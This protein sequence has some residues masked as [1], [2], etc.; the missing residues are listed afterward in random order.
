MSAGREKASVG[1]PSRTALRAAG[2]IIIQRGHRWAR[3][4]GRSPR[5]W[6]AKRKWRRR[7]AATFEPGHLKR[8][9][10]PGRQV[11]GRPY[12]TGRPHWAAPATSRCGGG[13]FGRFVPSPGLRRH[14]WRPAG[15][16][17]LAAICMPPERR[18]S[19]GAL[20]AGRRM[21]C[22][23]KG[24]Q[25]RPGGSRAPERPLGGPLEGLLARKL[26]RLDRK[27]VV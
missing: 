11:A 14:E 21:L 15:R 3:P 2:S 5:G 20:A 19:R 27:S 17:R 25:P 7:V 22:Q 1:A 10:P 9:P 6:R 16:H 23:S 18:L 13:A 24:V 8:N 26:E 12:A 4:A